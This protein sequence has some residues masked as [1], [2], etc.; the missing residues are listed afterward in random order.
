MS[1]SS[2]QIVVKIKRVGF[3]TRIMRFP[4]VFIKHY[5][6]LMD[7]NIPLT[8]AF[9]IAWAFSSFMIRI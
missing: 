2:I 3:F 4:K 9:R 6:L 1:A 5:E 7:K 8:D